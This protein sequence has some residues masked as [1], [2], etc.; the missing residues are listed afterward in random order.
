MNS[1][2]NSSF[3]QAAE[4]VRAAIDHLDTSSPTVDGLRELALALQR[5]A[6]GNPRE[7]ALALTRASWTASHEWFDL[8]DVE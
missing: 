7:A 3:T 8:V 4:S 1:C 2:A 5:L 6:E